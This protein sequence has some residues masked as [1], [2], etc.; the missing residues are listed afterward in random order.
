MI[1]R[2]RA[3]LDFLITLMSPHLHLLQCWNGFNSLSPYT[4][5]P[6]SKLQILWHNLWASTTLFYPWNHD[7]TSSAPADKMSGPAPHS[8]AYNNQSIGWQL[9]TTDYVT[10]ILAF[11]LVAARLYT[12]Y[13]LT[14]SPGW[15]DGKHLPAHAS[16]P[17]HGADGPWNSHVRCG[18]A[19]C[20][21]S[22]GVRLS[23][24]AHIQQFIQSTHI[25]PSLTHK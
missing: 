3:L 5:P 14:R 18:L 17:C 1:C 7:Y 25:F 10:V 19:S 24:Y 6:I 23:R 4:T 9:I 8:P 21:R 2:V 16:S 22:F 15:E 13:F 11:V 12:K 20:N